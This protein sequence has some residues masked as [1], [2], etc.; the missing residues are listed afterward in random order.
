VEIPAPESE[1]ISMGMIE[2][3]DLPSPDPP[4]PVESDS[5]IQRRQAMDFWKGAIP[6]EI[7][8]APKP[9]STYGRPMVPFDAIIDWTKPQHTEAPSPDFTVDAFGVPVFGPDSDYTPH[10]GRKR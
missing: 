7:P 1:N 6:N 3:Y 9:A 5:E 4:A 2:S 10:D 8:I